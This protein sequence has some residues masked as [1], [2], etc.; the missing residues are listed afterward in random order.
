MKIRHWATLS[1]ATVMGLSHGALAGC[2]KSGV[3]LPGG[4]LEQVLIALG[5]ECRISVLVQASSATSF[6]LPEQTLETAAGDFEPALQA[7]LRDSP[8]TYHR[9]GP[10]A[11]AV[12]PRDTPPEETGGDDLPAQTEEITVTGSSLTGSHLRHLQLDS[13]APIDVLAQPELEITGAQTVAQLLK[14]LP[15]VS[16]NSTSTSVSNG[17]NGT[18]TVTLRGLPASNTL[19]LI[20]GRRIVSNGFGGEAADLNTIPLSAVERVEILKDGASAVYGSDAIAGVVNIILRRNFDGLSV[21]SYFGEAKRG[22]QQTGSHSMTWGKTGDRGHLMLSLSRYRQ[23]V[24]MSRD[25][26]LSESADNRSRGGTDLRSAASPAGYIALGSGEVVT[27]TAAGGYR[28]W[29]QEDRYDYRG[30]TSAVVPS[31]RD[32]AYLAGDLDLDDQVELFVEAMG[33]RTRAQT[34]MAP[35]PVFTR[36]DNGDL[37]IAAD[38]PHNPFGEEIT[39]VRKRILE[40]GPRTQENRTETWRFNSGLKGNWD[41]WQ[42]ELTAAT[43]YTRASEILNGLID[44]TRLSMGLKGPGQCNADSGCVPVNLLGPSGSIDDAQLDFIR[45]ESEVDGASRMVSLTYVADGIVGSS[46]TGEILAAA[47]VELRREAIDFKSTDAMGLSFIGSNVSGAA[48]GERIIGEV[49]AEISLPLAADKLWLDGAIRYSDYSDF[50]NTANPKLALR[51]RPWPSL[52]VRASYATGFKAP[53]LIDMNQTGY[54]SQEFL[55]DP[56]TRNDANT[57]PGCRGQADGARIQY[58]TEFGGNAELE[59]ETSDNRSL[60][61]VWTPAQL[62]GFSA[63]LDMFDIRQND[64]ID[65]SPQYLIDQNAREALFADRVLRDE[66]GDIIKIVARRL[67]IG[68][69]EVRGLDLAM[70]YEYLSEDIGQLRWSLNASHIQRYLDQ[71]APGSPTEDLAGTFVDPASGGAGSLPKWKANTGV[72]WS[73]GRWEG[74][75]TIHHVGALEESFTIDEQRVTRRIDSWSSHDL[76]LAYSLP[77]GLRLAAGIDN[78]LDQAPPFAAT[79]FNDNYDGRTYDLSGRYWYTTLAYS[80]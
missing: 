5:R 13:Y 38:S 67:N 70:R 75:Y 1:L 54:Q 37:A 78:L 26:E 24:L 29:S 19:V 53:T 31:R 34:T 44:P 18:A 74:G 2:P 36:F 52:M 80:F 76:Q 22:D 14:F 32:S 60:G 9:H 40:L 58:L 61:L 56:C 50:G 48:E 25:R 63:T 16:G 57:L 72:Y 27:N 65:T 79:A 68:A 62:K 43:H 46:G 69:R 23:G 28:T 66:R 8:F 15:A 4:S 17:G 45:A 64:V 55:F 73:K 20:N 77:V 11:V 71:P 39:D 35:T 49:F 6:K 42:W 33:I 41:S 12:V 10:A 30:Y 7:L 59:P 21:N 47:G 51:W 3:H